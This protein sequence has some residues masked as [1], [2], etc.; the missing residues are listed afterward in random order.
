VY[1]RDFIIITNL[2]LLVNIYQ[3]W[4]TS[5]NEKNPSNYFIS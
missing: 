1:E 2:C 3:R 5:T 4:Y